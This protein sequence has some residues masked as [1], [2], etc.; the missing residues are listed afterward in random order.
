MIDVFSQGYEAALLFCIGIAA[1]L[2]FDLFTLLRGFAGRILCHAVDLVYVLSASA[3]LLFGTLLASNG[4]MRLFYVLSFGAGTGIAA[5]AFAP[6]F[7]GKLQ[8]FR[9]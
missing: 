4:D 5:W 1:G 3:L 8:K 7:F 6:L 2:L 9:N